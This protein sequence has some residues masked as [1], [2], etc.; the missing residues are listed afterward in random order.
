MPV[1]FAI[2]GPS[3]LDH[4]VRPSSLI[5]M[6]APLSPHRTSF[7]MT[8]PPHLLHDDRPI[9]MTSP[10][11]LITDVPGVLVGNAHDERLASGV[12]IALFE[13]PA[14]ASGVILGGAPANRDTACLEPEA[15]VEGVNGIVLSGGSAFGLDAASGVQAFMR[16]RGIG[17]AVGRMRVP[18]VPQA[19]CF[20]L[21]NGGDK[22][23]GRYP[24]YRELAYAA[25]EAAAGTFALGTAGGGYGATTVDLKG[26]LG[27]ASAVTP[28][29]F[30]VGALVV[31]NA[32]GS[33]VI[34]GGPHFWA[35]P[36]EE[37]NEFG[38]LG[39]PA[40]IA[41]EMRRLAWKGG[42]AKE[43]PILGTTIALVATDAALPKAMAKRLAVSAHGGL[44][45]ALSLSHALYDGDTVFSAATARRPLGVAANEIIEICAHAADC[46][47]RAIAR[48][49]YEATALPF[50]GALPAWKDRFPVKSGTERSRP[51]QS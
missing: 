2:M 39:A 43:G 20:D 6:T 28:S 42:R 32:I 41:P 24:P 7:T 51:P 13:E 23:W 27:S 21:L 16:E 15:V 29:G 37:G 26:G 19:I 35:A 45:K 1:S 4:R 31:V 18:V 36:F 11:N 14:V 49:I 10:S 30:T 9:E 46:M 38:G 48:G 40:H 22:D 50:P 12:T 47:A 17:V 8:G 3:S 34:G 44:A 25:C 33:A 5:V